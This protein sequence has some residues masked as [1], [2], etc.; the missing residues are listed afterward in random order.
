MR[1]DLWGTIAVAAAASAWG[2]WALFLRGHGLPPQWQ[3]VMI[4][5]TMS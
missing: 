4:L 1:R 3:S 5:S 2:T